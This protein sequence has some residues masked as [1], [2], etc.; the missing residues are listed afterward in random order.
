MA[1]SQSKSPFF[2]SDFRRVFPV[3]LFAFMATF[4]LISL[5]CSVVAYAT[6]TPESL[7]I[8]ALGFLVLYVY[9]GYEVY[10]KPT[11]PMGKSP[12]I[13][14]STSG[15]NWQK[16]AEDLDKSTKM[17]IQRDLE[18]T[19][20]NEQLQQIDK[21]K[22]DF[23]SVVTHQLR[24]P[25]SGIRWSLS[26]ILDGEMGEISPDQKTYLMK[27]YESNNRMISLINDMLQAD[28]IDSG[29]MHHNFIPTNLKYLLENVLSE[30]RRVAQENGITIAFQ[31][32][33]DIP[34]LS[35]D[36][37]SMR[38]V[39]QNLIDNAVKYSKPNSEVKVEIAKKKKCLEVMIKDHG[40]G[41]PKEEQTNIFKRFFRAP[42][43]VHTQTDGS[44]L[45]LYIVED[46]VKKHHGEIRFTSEMNVGTTFYVTLPINKP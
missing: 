15:I 6:L 4:I 33:E 14:K 8:A 30:V 26:M 7:T 24:T 36:P 39:L 45:G 35:I 13:Q 10:T 20:A 43:A 22:S 23:V 38:I 42:N 31:S 34:E 46:I 25:L 2:T 16:V 40:I 29:T 32:E 21:M 44:G 5:L 17:L 1:E 27:T 37:E 12:D 18:L 3:L 28:R 41:I 9:V 19:R 11:Q